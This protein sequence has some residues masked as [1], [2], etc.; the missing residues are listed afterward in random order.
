MFCIHNS[1][2]QPKNKIRSHHESIQ[3]LTPADVYAGRD[4]EILSKREK[5]KQNTL[6][7]RRLHNLEKVNQNAVWN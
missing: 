3:N 1:Q 2:Y 4:K 5:I 7:I 6:N